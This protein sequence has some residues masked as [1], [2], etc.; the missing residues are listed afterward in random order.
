MEDAVES[1]P[2]D[3]PLTERLTALIL[4]A[5]KGRE[6]TELDAEWTAYYRLLS[7][8]LYRRN[9]E[10]FILPVIALET[11]FAGLLATG[12]CGR[13]VPALGV[14]WLLGLAASMAFV[15]LLGVLEG[16]ASGGPASQAA[17]LLRELRG[18]RPIIEAA[19]SMEQP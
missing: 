4:T 2:G 10:T 17:E 6:R 5:A 12:F 3:A 18:T 14:F 7:Q 1:V 13:W 9:T 19:Q 15:V 8:Y 11:S 16:E